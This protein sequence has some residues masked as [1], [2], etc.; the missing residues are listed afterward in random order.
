MTI[1]NIITLTTHNK[2]CKNRLHAIGHIHYIR[3]LLHFSV[4][5]KKEEADTKTLT[6][7]VNA[8]SSRHRL[9]LRLTFSISVMSPKPQT[10]HMLCSV[11]MTI[12]AENIQ[13]V[14]RIHLKTYLMLWGKKKVAKTCLESG[15]QFYWTMQSH[16]SSRN[17]KLLNI[18]TDWNF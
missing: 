9:M 3:C 5:H 4:F 6:K 13:Q 8:F 7:V 14:G 16:Q 10:S 11:H 2:T 1:F 18:Y 15:K 17:L 12:K